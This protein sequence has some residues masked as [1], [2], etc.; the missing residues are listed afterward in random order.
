MIDNLR[1]TVLVVVVSWRAMRIEVDVGV[2]LDTGALGSHFGGD[3]SLGLAV[4]AE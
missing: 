1:P 4:N 3:A 2:Y